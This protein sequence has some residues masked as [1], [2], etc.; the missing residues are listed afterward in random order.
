MLRN[1]VGR[2]AACQPNGAT[3]FAGGDLEKPGVLEAALAARASKSRE[4][5]FLSV[6]DTRDHRRQYK[7]PALRTISID[8][9]LNLLANLRRLGLENVFILTTEALCRRFQREYC[10]YGCG[11]TSLWHS[12]SGLTTWGL[13][14]GDMFVRDWRSNS[15]P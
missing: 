15:V 3:A 14:P 1:F 10:L 2:P 8:F 9:I 13:R 4:L 6:G 12:H 5:I 7:D 11:W